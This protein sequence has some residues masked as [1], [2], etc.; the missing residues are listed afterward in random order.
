MSWIKQLLSRRRFYSDLSEEIQ[1]HL[2]EK[3]DELVASGMSRE[4]AIHAARR[5][6]GNVTLLEER[7]RE[8]WQWAAI[9]NL[10]IDVRYGLRNVAPQPRLHGGGGH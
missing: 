9:E 2:A 5:Q 7:S 6:F 4:D 3:I 10:F 1:E 8:I